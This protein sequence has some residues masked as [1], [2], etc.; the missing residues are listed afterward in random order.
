MAELKSEFF[1]MQNIVN[2][3][4][5][6][7]EIKRYILYINWIC[8]KSTEFHRIPQETKIIKKE[9]SELRQSLQCE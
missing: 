6:S 5:V 1:L 4:K 2:T 7:Q 8:Q 9:K 3:Y